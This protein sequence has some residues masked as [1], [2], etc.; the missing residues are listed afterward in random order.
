MMR[1]S[2]QPARTPQPLPLPLPLPPPPLSLPSSPAAPRRGRHRTSSASSSSSSS[3]SSSVSAAY[4]FSFCPSP[5]PAASPP[6]GSAAS[7]VPFSWER[8]AGVPKTSFH[9][10]IADGSTGVPLPLPPPLRPAARRRRRHRANVNAA[11]SSSNFG[12]SNSDPF[13]AAFTECTREDGEDHGVDV[14]VADNKLWLAR[15]KPAASSGRAERRWW[16]SAS[17]GFLDLYGCKSALAVT[18][19]AILACRP[20]VAHGRRASRRS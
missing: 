9:G 12:T 2:S 10:D 16:L 8:H 15:A 11:A 13:V 17:V 20:V 1:T 6:R 18:D 4:S 14:A 5:S 7:L 19:G 3:S